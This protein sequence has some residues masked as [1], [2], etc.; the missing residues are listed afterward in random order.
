MALLLLKLN[1]CAFLHRD[2]NRHP[3]SHNWSLA[4][5]AL[6]SAMQANCPRG[7]LPMTNGVSE[8]ITTG[9]RPSG[10]G[11]IPVNEGGGRLA[12]QE[13]RVPQD[14]LQEQ[15]VGFHPSDVELIQGSLH[16]LYRMQV[17]VP[18]AYDLQK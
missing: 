14:V 18:S 11:M 17:G 3:S 16:L 5:H 6:S 9:M 15:N 10:C 8:A 13:L 12:G 7:P 1:S 4:E 2:V